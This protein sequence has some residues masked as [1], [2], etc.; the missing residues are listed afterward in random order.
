MLYNLEFASLNISSRIRMLISSHRRCSIKK[1]V[2]KYFAQFAEKHLYW[3]L[4][5]I[6]LQGSRSA[7]LLKRDS[8][9]GAF[10]WILRNFWKHLVYRTPPGGCFWMQ[11]HWSFF[12]SQTR[13]GSCAVSY[14]SPLFFKVF[15]YFNWNYSIPKGRKSYLLAGKCVLLISVK[16]LYL[17]LF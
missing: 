1:D 15:L 3:S 2:L 16:Y 12:G 17:N 7:A 5:I 13:F 10:L 9:T 4:F 8:N 11:C 14:C 6:K